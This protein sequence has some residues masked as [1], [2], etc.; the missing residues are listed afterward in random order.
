M[1]KK[2]IGLYTF[3]LNKEFIPRLKEKNFVFIKI[4]YSCILSK[5][6]LKEFPLW[7]F[8]TVSFIKALAEPISGLLHRQ[9]I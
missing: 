2:N 6:T 8:I 9:R 7:F 1:H 5:D 4:I 3:N